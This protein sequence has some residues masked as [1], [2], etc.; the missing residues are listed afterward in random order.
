MMITSLQR[1]HT[2]FRTTTEPTETI[3]EHRGIAGAS[4]DCR[5]R[6]HSTASAAAGVLTKF[7]KAVIKYIQGVRERARQELTTQRSYDTTTTT[8]AAV[9]LI[10]QWNK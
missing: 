7:K 9:N 8:P 2:Q 1:H 4:R 10:A 3:R 6:L 5:G